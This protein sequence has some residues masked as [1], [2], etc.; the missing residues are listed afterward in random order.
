MIQVWYRN[1]LFFK[2]TFFVTLFWT[3]I[4]PL[5]YLGALGFGFGRYVPPIE[6]L[7]FIDFYYPG[8][9]CSTAMMVAYFEA[10][11]PNYTKLTHQKIYFSMLLTPLTDV[12][13]LSGE[14][15]WAATKAL[16]G[17]VG[18]IL[19]SSLFGLFKLEILYTLPVLFLTSL[20]FA[21]FG[22]IMISIAKNYDTF[23][24]STSGLIVPLSMLSG[25][26]FSLNDVPS[27]FKY[28]AYLFPLAH[29]T[30]VVRGVAHS[31]FQ[32]EYFLNGLVIVIYIVVFYFLARKLFR[33][34]LIQ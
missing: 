33:K 2:K 25:V 28:L 14:I 18:V 11:Y 15:L 29:A 5:I 13:I 4:E 30:K 3:V 26:Y 23:I 17:V 24:F 7:P 16:F 10:T 8:L 19:V 34:K 22:M 1:F 21:C 12:Q 31:G 20:A 27:G 9:L 6:G 32:Q